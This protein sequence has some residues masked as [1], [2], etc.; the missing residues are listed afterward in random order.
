VPSVQVPEVSIQF[1]EEELD[2]LVRAVQDQ[3][4]DRSYWSDSSE[5]ELLRRLE[6]AQSDLGRAL[7]GDRDRYTI[8]S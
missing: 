4:G 5:A 1:N 2:V 3:A 6:A 8:V 7:R